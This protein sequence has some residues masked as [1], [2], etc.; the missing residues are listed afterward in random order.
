[1]LKILIPIIIIVVLVIVRVAYSFGET[2][3]REKNLC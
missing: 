3:G 2:K 1:M